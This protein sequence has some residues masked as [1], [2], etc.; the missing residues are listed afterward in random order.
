MLYQLVAV[1]RLEITL[2]QTTQESDPLQAGVTKGCFSLEGMKA[3]AFEQFCRGPRPD[4]RGPSAVGI[5]AGRRSVP[6][7]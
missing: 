7:R 1:G 3:D 2:V 5:R 4:L 6:A